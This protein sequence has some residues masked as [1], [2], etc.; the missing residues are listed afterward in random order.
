[1]K[2]LALLWC[3]IVLV[4]ASGCRPKSA[5]YSKKLKVPYEQRVLNARVQREAELRTRQ[6]PVRSTYQEIT[7]EMD[8]AINRILAGKAADLSGEPHDL[9]DVA[10]RQW[11]VEKLILLHNPV[12]SQL[13]SEL[14]Q[15]SAYPNLMLVVLNQ[16]S[17]SGSAALSGGIFETK[18]GESGDVEFAFSEDAKGSYSVRAGTQASLAGFFK[19]AKAQ[20]GFERRYLAFRHRLIRKHHELW[21]AVESLTREELEGRAAAVELLRDRILGLG[22]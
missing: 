11:E 8:A 13:L 16:L 5:L 19:D 17:L 9:S 18:V 3:T 15:M 22:E 20:I 10:R 12:I 21:Q 7:D 2:N 14:D 4:G 6:L 1:M